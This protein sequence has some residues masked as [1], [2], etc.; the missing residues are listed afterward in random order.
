MIKSYIG[1][2][3]VGIVVVAAII[4]GLN[5]SGSPAATRAAKFDQQ[6]ISDLY[7][8]QSSIN[9]YY[10]QNKVL[11]PSAADA[12]NMYNGSIKPADPETKMN[13]EYIPGVNNAYQLCATFSAKS[14]EA[15][16]NTPKYSTYTEFGEHPKGHH[17]F[18]VSVVN[19]I[20]SRE[21]VPQR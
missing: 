18:S 19:P 20:N 5:S 6:R 13:Y 10:T 2:F 21:F 4:Y 15:K 9:S 8:I 7:M 11:P 17:C 16:L 12:L 14:V 3:I 1:I